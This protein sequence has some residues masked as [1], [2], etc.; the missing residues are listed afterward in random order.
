LRRFLLHVLPVVAYAGGIFLLSSRSSL[1]TP[2]IVGFDKV[3]H[4]GVYGGLAFLAARG[5]GG[6]G[7]APSRAAVFGALLATLYGG[8]DELHQS[9]V[10]GRTMEL[11]DLVADALGALAGGLAWQGWARRKEPA[12]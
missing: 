9:F 3:A 11:A 4:F 1:P 2:G 8:S 10:P 6:Y 5:A 12:R 7:M